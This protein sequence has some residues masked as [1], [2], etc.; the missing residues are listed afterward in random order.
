MWCVCGAVCHRYKIPYRASN[1]CMHHIYERE[2]VM[3]AVGD[4]VRRKSMY[5]E[6]MVVNIPN[7]SYMDVYV[8]VKKCVMSWPQEDAEVTA[9]SNTEYRCA[10]CGEVIRGPATVQAPFEKDGAGP[11]LIHDKCRN[12]GLLMSM[13]MTEHHTTLRLVFPEEYKWGFEIIPHDNT[14][15]V[16][17]WTELCPDTMPTWAIAEFKKMMAY[18][19]PQFAPRR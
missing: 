19:E 8:H 1:K 13:Y 12:E 7:P 10:D 16:N 17:F 18:Y 3:F 2:V 6:G 4:R 11:E 14:A 9:S 5:S 15:H